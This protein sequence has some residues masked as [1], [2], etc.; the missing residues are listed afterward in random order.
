MELTQSNKNLIKAF[1]ERE[2]LDFTP[3][4]DE[5]W[6]NKVCAKIYR[7]IK[8]IK[9]GNYV[10]IQSFGQAGCFSRELKLDIYSGKADTNY[11]IKLC[12]CGRLEH[13]CQMT[14]E[15]RL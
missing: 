4:K 7:Q 15:K 10:S 9:N 13:T 12:T 8:T 11:F 6:I 3:N 1:I 14:K 2:A 5:S